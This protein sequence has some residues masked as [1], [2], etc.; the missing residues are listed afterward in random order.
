[1]K[2][3]GSIVLMTVISMVCTNAGMAQNTIRPAEQQIKAAVSAAPESLRA[4]AMVLGYNQ[5]GKLVTLRKGS[6]ENLL[7]CLADDPTKS[8]FHVAC[9]YKELEPFMKYGREMRAKGKNHEEVDSLRIVAI[10][11]GQFKMPDGPSALY[12]L[13]GGKDAFDYETGTVRKARPLYVVYIPYATEAS[14]G[15]SKEPAS[16]GAPWIMESGQPWAHIMISTGRMVG[17]EVKD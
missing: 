1:M 4:G 13:T 14:T 6:E 12:S 15:L 2:N 11:E 9:Y 7:I 8:N 3:L 17:S 10:K 16:K 5:K